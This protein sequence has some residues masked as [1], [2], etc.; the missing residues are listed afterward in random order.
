MQ[1]TKKAVRQT[2]NMK[3]KTQYDVNQRINDIMFPLDVEDIRELKPT[4]CPSESLVMRDFE[5]GMT[6]RE[7]KAMIKGW[8]EIN[9]DGEECEVWV[10]TGRG[11]SSPVT[12]AGPLNLREDESGNR[13]ADFILGRDAS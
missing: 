13:T 1:S 8:P 2:Q 6:V 10:Q 7:L 5:N 4:P 3:P 11:I 9:Q 12:I